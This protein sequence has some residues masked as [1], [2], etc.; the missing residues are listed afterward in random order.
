MDISEKMKKFGG[1]KKWK[2]KN[3]QKIINCLLRRRLCQATQARRQ[4]RQI[5]IRDITPIH[6]SIFEKHVKM[7]VY[8]RHIK[9]LV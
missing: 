6:A 9:K 1:E 2:M 3:S 5:I 7:C 4:R 8:I